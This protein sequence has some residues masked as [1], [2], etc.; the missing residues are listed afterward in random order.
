[1]KNLFIK[2]HKKTKEFKNKYD[3]NY[4]FQF[5]LFLKYYS[6]FNQVELIG[7]RRLVNWAI[8]IRSDMLELLTDKSLKSKLNQISDCNFFI[9]NRLLE[10]DKLEEIIKNTD[11]EQTE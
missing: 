2:S 11:I 5:S 6:N 10:M 7:T 3:I 8:Q 1:M 4:Q 9:N